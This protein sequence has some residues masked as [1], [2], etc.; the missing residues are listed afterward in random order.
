MS[1]AREREEF[2]KRLKQKLKERAIEASPSRVARIFNELFPAQR[3]SVQGARKWLGAEAMPG[4]GK[5]RALA[6]WL[7]VAPEW[8]QYG[9]EATATTA[10]QPAGRYGAVLSDEELVRR[11][12]KLRSDHQLALAE[13]I[14]ALSERKLGE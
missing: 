8:L 2:S 5:I 14:T 1:A 6:S 11:Y 12:R 7:E 3:I 10:R 4:R 9:H 13:I